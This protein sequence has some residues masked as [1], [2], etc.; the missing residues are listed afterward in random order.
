MKQVKHIV[1]TL[2]NLKK[3]KFCVRR[4]VSPDGTTVFLPMVKRPGLFNGWLQIVV[5]YG[6]AY[7]M[8]LP[9]TNHLSLTE[10]HEHIRLLKEQLKEEAR[11][12][13]K[14]EVSFLIFSY[15]TFNIG[16]SMA[17]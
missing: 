10:C 3:Y 12:S 14:P 5:I 15:D 17:A 16:N 1:R 13:K 8:E 11:L 2:K 4:T 9:D 7:V 6:K